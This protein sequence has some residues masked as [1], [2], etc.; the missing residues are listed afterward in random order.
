MTGTA[1]TSAGGP[2]SLRGRLP[3]L[4]RSWRICRIG[5]LNERAYR[6]RLLTGPAML[7]VQLF[8]YD[9]L[10]V[11][12]FR[13]TTSAGGLDARQTVTYSLIALLSTRIRLSARVYAKDTV[14]VVIREGTVAYWF[15]RPI[16]PARY[17]M[18]RQAGDMAY[19][20]MW[21]VIGY[22][23]LLASGLINGPVT[24]AAGMYFAASLLLGQ[25][26]L[27]YLGTVVDVCTF[28]LV[29]E[30]GLHPMYYFVQ[31]LL[32]GVFVPLWFLPGWLG[33]TSAW[34]PFNAGINVPL[35]LYVGRTPG[36][37]AGDQLRD[38]VLWIVALALATRLLWSRAARRV[39]VQG[40]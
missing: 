2:R 16:S 12:V 6:T 7:A 19:G 38:Q 10:W 3:W 17:Y 39:T 15:L 13:H 18:W 23:V 5:V 28:W 20:T 9:R 26:V 14:S 31:D 27:Y 24:A 37:R 22:A 32:T 4:T 21:A 40:G 29:D 35:S 25:I 11:A 8:L 36:V 30:G 34:S 1:L 33:A